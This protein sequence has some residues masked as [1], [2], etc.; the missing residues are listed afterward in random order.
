[1]CTWGIHIG[2]KILKTTRYHWVHKTP[3]DKRE[4]WGR[5]VR[6][7]NGEWAIYRYLSK[8]TGTYKAGKFLLGNSETLGHNGYLANVPA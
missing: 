2:M 4:K 7:Q 6:F 3:L 8:R 5:S 1:M